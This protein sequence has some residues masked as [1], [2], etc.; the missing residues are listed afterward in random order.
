M[1]ESLSRSTL[2]PMERMRG[3]VQSGSMLDWALTG[4]GLFDRLCSRWPWKA[5]TLGR[6]RQHRLL[7]SLP[8]PPT[9]R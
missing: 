2:R 1:R 8:S 3:R 9:Q 5:P 4:L 7:L 6:Q